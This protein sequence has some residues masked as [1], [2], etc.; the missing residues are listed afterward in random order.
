METPPQNLPQTPSSVR[1]R[2]DE[3]ASIV[4]RRLFD[5][6]SGLDL[7]HDRSAHRRYHYLYEDLL[8]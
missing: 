4:D 7:D 2:R 1:A 8:M 3:M 6:R 5:R